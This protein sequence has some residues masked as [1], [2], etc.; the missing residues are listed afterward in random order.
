MEGSDSGFFFHQTKEGAGL[1][2]I[3]LVHLQHHFTLL[4]EHVVLVD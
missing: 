4:K 2:K 1:K 3:H